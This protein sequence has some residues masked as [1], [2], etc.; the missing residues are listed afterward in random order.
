MDMEDI[1]MNIFVNSVSN[2]YT[3]H[4]S[5]HFVYARQA[6]GMKQTHPTNVGL[7]NDT[8]I[9]STSNSWSSFLTSVS[10]RMGLNQVLKGTLWGA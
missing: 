1:I 6:H 2:K 8:G 4:F 5:V 3:V 9:T 7:W 10:G